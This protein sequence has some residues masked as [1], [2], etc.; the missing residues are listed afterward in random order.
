AADLLR[1]ALPVLVSHRC[2]TK[3]AADLA[4]AHWL[5]SPRCP[6]GNASKFL[7]AYPDDDEHFR[8]LAGALDAATQGLVGPEILSD[9][10]YRPGSVVYYRFGGFSGD[11]VLD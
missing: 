7:T 2:S 4:W 5:N 8:Q 9:R 10:R 1:R 11:V 6:R 3:F